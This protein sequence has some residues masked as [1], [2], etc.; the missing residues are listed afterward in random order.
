MAALGLLLI[1]ADAPPATPS[2][3]YHLEA[4]SIARSRIVA[5]GRDMVIDGEALSHAV[6]VNGSMRVAGTVGG[7]LIALGGDVT[8]APSARVAGD[9]FVLGGTIEASPGADIGGRSVAYPDAS[10]IALTLLEGPT[11]GLSSSS[12]VVVG[13]KLALLAFWALLVLLLFAISGR[14]VLSTSES[15][16]IE[17]FR[18][19]AVGLTGVLAMVLTA[20]IFSTLAGAL[21]GV[22]LLVLVAVAALV[23]RFWGMVAVF[24]ALGAWIYQVSKRRPPLP[25]TAATVG[26]LALGVVKFLPWVGMIVWTMA[27]FIGVGAT[28]A[29]KLGRREPW[30]ETG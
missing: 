28:L 9:V 2:P 26:L 23:L 6:V 10:A 13:A 22:P 30:F 20:L 16:R 17:P 19:F 1:A 14:E 29:T 18:N 4:G 3:A 21:L 7:D 27:T 25:L 12:M 24:H 8:L 5:L 15:V 11:L